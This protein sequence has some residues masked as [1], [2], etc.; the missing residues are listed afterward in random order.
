LLRK[1]GVYEV[2][3]PDGR[4]GDRTIGAIAAFRSARG[5]PPG[6]PRLD[7]VLVA[8]LQAADDEGWRR[9]IADTRATG[10]P[11]ASRIMD[12]QEKIAGAGLLAT[13]LG[14]G[15]SIATWLAPYL[16]AVRQFM[17]AVRPIARPLGRLISDHWESILLV[18]GP[19]LLWQAARAWFARREDYR[20]GRAM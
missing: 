7:R 13:L 10:K 5:L 6:V 17:D 18:G 20:K 4:V 9:P 15:T 14:L 2:G 11:K 12:A 3:E 19:F 8:E 16:D 1:L